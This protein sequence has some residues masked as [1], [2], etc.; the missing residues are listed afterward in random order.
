MKKINK[1]ILEA[2]NRGIQLALDDYQDI[3]DN[4]SISQ[5]NNVIDAEDII[6]EKILYKNAKK[7]FNDIIDKWDEGDYLFTKNDLKTLAR[8][9]NKWGF[10]YVG[11]DDSIYIINE[12]IDLIC[13]VDPKADLNWIDTSHI[14]NLNEVFSHGNATKFNGDISKWDTSN[15]ILMEGTFLNSKFTGDISKWDVSNVTKMDHMFRDSKFNGDISKWDVS[16]VETMY[17]MFKNSQFNQDISKWEIDNDCTISG[18]FDK[19]NIKE[20]YIPY[21][22][23]D[24]IEDGDTENE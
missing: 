5:T 17:C 18:M 7:T 6:H 16:N 14:T 3:K 9:S 22:Y 23:W 21:K 2:V 4:S 12:T 11:L 1:Q 24:L 19:C 15:V 13:Q 20:K 8:L 10:K